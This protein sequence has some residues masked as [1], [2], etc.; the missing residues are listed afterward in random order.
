MA[1]TADSSKAVGLA[2]ES[3]PL[4]QRAYRLLQP[5][6]G[7]HYPPCNIPKTGPICSHAMQEQWRVRLASEWATL[8]YTLLEYTS[9][10]G[11]R[12][13]RGFLKDLAEATNMYGW[14]KTL[15]G[16]T[17]ILN[18]EDWL[19]ARGQRPGP[20]SRYGLERAI[21]QA[22]GARIIHVV[23]RRDL[24]GTIEVSWNPNW[25]EW[26]IIKPERRERSD[27][28][29]SFYLD[30]LASA[31]DDL[32]HDLAWLAALS[33][34]Q[35]KKARRAWV[36][37][38]HCQEQSYAF[39][40]EIRMQAKKV[41]IPPPSAEPLWR[42]AARM[43]QPGPGEHYPLCSI[44]SKGPVCPLIHVERSRGQLFQIYAHALMGMVLQYA[45]KNHDALASHVL[46]DLAQSTLAQ[47]VLV[48]EARPPQL[49][50]EL[51][52]EDWHVA[53]TNRGCA[54]RHNIEWVIDQALQAHILI[55]THERDYLG[56]IG[57]RWNENW[58][59]WGHLPELD[60]AQR[61]A[62][63]V[64][65]GYQQRYEQGLFKACAEVEQELLATQD[66]GYPNEYQEW[67]TLERS[68]MEYEKLAA[69]AG[70]SFR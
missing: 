43:V 47:P 15:P 40:Q 4:W 63:E 70:I 65:A 60:Q 66:P 5:G 8:V 24:Q 44:P 6:P 17:Y 27:R 45:G 68:W 33:P 48:T 18:I 30:S 1:E 69:E 34:D 59:E 2:L 41:E 54:I 37:H 32:E 49:S 62:E 42:Y 31:C 3:E 16:Y 55:R 28:F 67:V 56:M 21:T 53:H 39:R 11:Q 9:K 10:Q 46:S 38:A 36:S 25:T 58:T 13:M 22:V 50:F 51:N 12:L 23:Q 35:V 14:A 29:L 57:L 7:E 20:K 64:A 61:A 52:D 19:I 26:A